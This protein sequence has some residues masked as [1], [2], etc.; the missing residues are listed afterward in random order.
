MNRPS[1]DQTGLIGKRVEQPNRLAAV[2]RDL[3]QTG[4]FSLIGGDGHPLAIR[5][6]GGGAA[7]VE[8]VCASA[9]TFVP[10]AFMT[11]RPAVPC[12]RYEKQI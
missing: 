6:P 7:H 4:A 5:G 8:G 2:H 11:Y 12:L 3:E 10:L 1:G 9:R